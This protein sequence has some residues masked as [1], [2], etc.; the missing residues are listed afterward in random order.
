MKDADTIARPC[1]SWTKSVQRAVQVIQLGRL[2]KRPVPDDALDALDILER[3]RRMLIFLYDIIRDILAF[4]VIKPVLARAMIPRRRG[5]ATRATVG[6][7]RAPQVIRDEGCVGPPPGELDPF[8]MHGTR[9]GAEAQVPDGGDL[10]AAGHHAAVHEDST[11]G[12]GRTE[13]G[14]GDRP[15]RGRVVVAVR[16]PN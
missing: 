6:H 3:R 4:T 10:E 11:V 1:F 2:Y 13:H 8:H 14:R 12:R 16:I 15:A 9:G 7:K 5:R